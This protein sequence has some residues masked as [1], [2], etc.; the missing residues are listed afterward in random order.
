MLVAI[1]V[2]LQAA[3]IAWGAFGI[4]NDS[5]NGKSFEKDSPGAGFL[6]HSIGGNAIVLITLVLLIVSFFAHI[7]GGVKWAAITFGVAVLQYA[8][9][10]VSFPVPVLGMLHGINAFVLAGVASIAMRKARVAGPAA[11]AAAAGAP[12]ADPLRAD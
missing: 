2:V 6:A 8:L 7:P 3:F 4:F 5:D 1:G 12:I 10:V 9:V 11:D